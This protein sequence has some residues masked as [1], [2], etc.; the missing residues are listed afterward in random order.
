MTSF[1]MLTVTWFY[2][3]PETVTHISN[4]NANHVNGSAS[5]TNNSQNV[6]YQITNCVFYEDTSKESVC[7]FA[8]LIH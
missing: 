4:T 8:H 3:A 2:S 6:N 5:I 7:M 1:C